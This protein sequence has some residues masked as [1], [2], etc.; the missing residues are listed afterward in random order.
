MSP[1]RQERFGKRWKGEQHPARHLCVAVAFAGQTLTAPALAAIRTAQ[2][3]NS[4]L[5]SAITAWEISIKAEKRRLDLDAEPEAW[6][7]RALALPGVRLAALTPGVLIK[8]TRLPDQ[9]PNDPADRI[10]LA[11]ARH[12]NALLVTRDGRILPWAAKGHARAIT[13]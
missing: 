6:F 9:P 12:H 7:A 11:T 13:C 2:S 8:S 3:I 4:V 10:I 5:I 1:L